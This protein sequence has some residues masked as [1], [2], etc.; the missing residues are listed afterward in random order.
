MKLQIKG[1]LPEETISWLKTKKENDYLFSSNVP[2]D[3]AL[4]KFKQLSEQLNKRTLKCH[5]VTWFVTNRCNLSCLHCGVS[6]NQRRFS[7]ISLADF[8]KIIPDLKELGVNFVSLTGGEPLIRKD[9]FEI[10]DLL[11]NSGFKVGMVTNASRLAEL[12]SRMGDN[13]IDSLSISI[14]GLE[15]NHSLIRKSK[16]NFQETI[17]GIKMAKE[18]GINIV[19]VFTC[20]YPD[21]L[22]DLDELREMIF[23]AGADQWVLRPVTPSGRASAKENYFLSP[24][25][26]R[27]LLYYV[28]NVLEQGF[29]V[30]VG[31]EIGYLGKLDSYLYLSPYF[32]YAGWHSFVVLPNGDIK[33]F[34]EL[35]L[36]VEGN[37]RK[38]DLKKIWFEGFNYYRNPELPDACLSCEYFSHCRGGHLPG[39][40]LGKRC[41]KPIIQLL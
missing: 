19:V 29:D 15:K 3:F 37:I 40:E 35:H 32:S 2:P 20:V 28:K 11:K 34:E 4:Q 39:A 31:G 5:Q 6:A 18:A 21:N 10:I 14:D 17:A 41:I 9:I 27:D 24:E 36:P 22:Q 26:V 30:S 12:C 23:S 13:K 7:E 33:G 25:Q 8:A 38:G 16:N 1:N